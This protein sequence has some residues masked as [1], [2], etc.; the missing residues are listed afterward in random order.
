MKET[1]AI[2]RNYIDCYSLDTPRWADMPLF[3]NHREEN[4]RGRVSL[5]S[6]KNMQRMLV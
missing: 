2:L 6:C 3:F 1:A 4:L 5:I